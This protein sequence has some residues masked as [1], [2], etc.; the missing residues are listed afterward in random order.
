VEPHKIFVRD[1]FD[2]KIDL[3]ISYK[4]AVLGGMVKVPTIDEMFDFTIPEG[5]QSGTVLPC[6]VRG[7]SRRETARATGLCV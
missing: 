1:R 6:A 7:L 3:P 4:T 2:L 5:T